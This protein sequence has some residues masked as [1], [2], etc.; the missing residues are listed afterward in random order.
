MNL[1]ET[2]KLTIIIVLASAIAIL[3]STLQTKI[4]CPFIDSYII[5]GII[6]IITHIILI[7]F[8]FQID[9]AIYEE[10]EE[11][12][13]EEL[14]NHEDP[15]IFRLI[16]FLVPTITYL[17]IKQQFP[18]STTF[19]ISIAITY[20]IFI[21]ADHI[22]LII[23]EGPDALEGIA[24]T[25]KNANTYILLAIAY[26]IFFLGSIAITDNNIPIINTPPPIIQQ[27]QENKTIINKISDFFH[28]LSQDIF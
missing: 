16:L 27:E 5:Q 15:L 6:I 7:G 22:Y 3:L 18:F 11:T 4:L 24:E 23:T 13:L 2:I 21:I 8:T 12:I 19:A 25:W 14:T 9:L 28:R 26:G 20:P 10:Q 17:L 1:P